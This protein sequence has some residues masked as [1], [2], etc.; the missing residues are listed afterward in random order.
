MSYSNMLSDAY[1]VLFV[2]LTCCGDV[3]YETTQLRCHQA[4]GR[5]DRTKVTIV[6]LPCQLF[7]LH[8]KGEIS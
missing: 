4:V 5:V 1:S 8:A 2:C 6:K 3:L 7:H